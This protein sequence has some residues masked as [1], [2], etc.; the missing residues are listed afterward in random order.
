MNW[1]KTFALMILMS[2][3]VVLAGGI[4][5]QATGSFLAGVIPALIFAFI[6]N[7]VAYWFSDKL[8][9][10]M[11]GA[12]QVTEQE[13]PRLHYIVAEVAR[14]AEL[15]KPKVYVIHQDSPNAFATGR[16]PQHAV[17]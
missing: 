1:T 3:L 17:V 8:A 10:M 11:S 16:N 13:E 4:I 5:G 9:L 14:M 7:F 2:A 12:K 6:M 15:P